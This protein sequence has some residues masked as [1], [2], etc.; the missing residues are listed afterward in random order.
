LQY[1]DQSAQTRFPMSTNTYTA[2][3]LLSW[4]ALAAL[5]VPCAQ[6]A[7]LDQALDAIDSKVIAWRR[8]FHQHPELSNR[9]VR[10]AKIV[11]DHLRKLGLPVETGIAHT[12]VVG[13]L[14]TG[15][16]GPTIALRADMDA[17]PVAERTD[18][19]FRSTAKSNY[20]GEEVGVMHA[21]GHDSHTAVLMGVAEALVKAKHTLRGNILFVFQPAEEGAPPGEVGG[22]SEML[23]AGIFE[24]YKPEVAFGWHAWA[25]L[26][27]GVIGYR[28][29]PLLA[30]SQ[31]WSTTVTGK[32][33]HGSRPWQGV[34]PIVVAA[35]IVNGLQTVVSRQVDI[36][37]NPAVVSVGIIKGGVRN[38]IIPDSVEMIGTIRTFERA[39]YEQVTQAMKRVVENTAAASGATATFTLDAYS[40]PV[41]YNDPELT[42]RVLPSLRKVAGEANV[43]EI[44]LITGAEDFAYFAQAVP[45]VFFFVGVTPKGTD[46]ATAPANHS[47]LFYI[48]ETAI[49]LATRALA[50]I[51][52]DYLGK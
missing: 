39:Q 45:S 1:C 22:A 51:A 4:V 16:P 5:F 27:S 17:L 28:S 14:K 50:Q 23:K 30:G 15:Q 13:L 19:P 10:T 25:S 42:A 47:P 38:N 11:A 48:D 43:K 37:R 41:T 24:K 29:G 33:T 35:Q 36:T 18:V 52:I 6:A 12:G 3:G 46:P 40:N 7:E 8:D 21:C 20:R 26:N 31:A 49:P 9:E 44:P 2:L 34:D 32:Q